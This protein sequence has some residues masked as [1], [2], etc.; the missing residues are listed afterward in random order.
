M[1]KILGTCILSLL[2][3]SAMAWFPLRSKTTLPATS[4]HEEIELIAGKVKAEDGIL[5]QRFQSADR[6]TMVEFRKSGGG[7]WQ[8]TRQIWLEFEKKFAVGRKLLVQKELKCPNGDPVLITKSEQGDGGFKGLVEENIRRVAD[9][10]EKTGGK[11]VVHMWFHYDPTDPANEEL[12]DH[13]D[14]LVL[15]DAGEHSG[16]D[17]AYICG[18]SLSKWNIP[19]RDGN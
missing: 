13:M 15:L 8:E 17:L 2:A 11:G 6:M 14:E 16:T 7:P 12:N 1:K 19:Y 4:T 18:L 10:E 3:V 9:Y 5:S